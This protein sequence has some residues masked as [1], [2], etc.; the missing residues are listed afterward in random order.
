VRELRTPCVRGRTAG[1]AHRCASAALPEDPSLKEILPAP[2][3]STRLTLRDGEQALIRST[4]SL[5]QGNISQAA[6]WLGIDR[7]TLRRKLR[8]S[9][10]TEL[11]T[12]PST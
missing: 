6:R 3:A 10:T 7:S 11:G 4:L 12:G 8:S 1:G 9:E 5:F 2:S